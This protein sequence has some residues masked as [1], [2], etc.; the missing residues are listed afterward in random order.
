MISPGR[1]VPI[2]ALALVC[3]ASGA[4]AQDDA[5]KV[6]GRVTDGSGA[7]LPGVTVTLTPAG[8]A[9]LSVVTDGVGQFLSPSLG[10]GLY[11]IAFALPG[12]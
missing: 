4:A 3:T 7:A 11:T 8:G 5:A 2:A 12:F 1:F 10:A 9:P 6:T